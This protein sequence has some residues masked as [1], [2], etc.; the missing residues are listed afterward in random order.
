[1]KP[2]QTD[3]LGGSDLGPYCLQIGCLK[4]KQTRK[5]AL[6]RHVVLA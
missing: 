1:M 2:D 5:T 3:P 6:R 4:H